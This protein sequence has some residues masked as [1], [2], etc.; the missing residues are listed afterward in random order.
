MF[1]KDSV[2]SYFDRTAD[3]LCIQAYSFL[4]DNLTGEQLTLW[5]NQEELLIQDITSSVAS[6]RSLLE[7]EK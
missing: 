6:C 5:K 7:Q 4:R 1:P 3:S 2:E